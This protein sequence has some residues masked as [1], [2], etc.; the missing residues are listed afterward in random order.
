MGNKERET[1]AVMYEVLNK[2]NK[3]SYEELDY[4]DFKWILDRINFLHSVRYGFGVIDYHTYLSYD[5]YRTLNDYKYIDWRINDS[6]TN[7]SHDEWL[8]DSRKECINNVIFR[9]NLYGKWLLKLEW[10]WYNFWFKVTG[11]L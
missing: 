3:T 1:L 5:E 9:Y 11:V 2:V 4:F 10:L 6:D 8:S 7:N